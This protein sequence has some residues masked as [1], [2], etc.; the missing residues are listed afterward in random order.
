M[1]L[2]KPLVL[3]DGH[4]AQIPAGDTLDASVVAI[5]VVEM[6][7]GETSTIQAGQPVYISGTDTVMLAQANALNSSKVFGL[8]REDIAAGATGMIQ[9]DGILELPDWTNITGSAALT[10]GADYFLD[11]DNAGKLTVTPPTTSGNY[12]VFIGRAISTTAIEI[13]I[14]RPI[15]L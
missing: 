1:A 4:I 15:I 12:L 7:N 11:P 2:R 8:A 6:T 10:A 3:V 14:A 5:D 13:E 9:V